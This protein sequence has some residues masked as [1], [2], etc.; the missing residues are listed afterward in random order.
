MQIVCHMLVVYV[1]PV[2]TPVSLV[3][4]ANSIGTHEWAG[5]MTRLTMRQWHCSLAQVRNINRCLYVNNGVL[6]SQQ[7]PVKC[8][9]RC[10]LCWQIGLAASAMKQL[11]FD[12]MVVSQL[13][14]AVPSLSASVQNLHI[15][16]LLLLLLPEKTKPRAVATSLAECPILMVRTVIS[17]SNN[18][19]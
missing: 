12:A 5:N 6:I 16:T 11:W 14:I 10:A 1:I 15:P 17:Q 4:L 7:N 18:P 3:V 19:T 13:T 8:L 2:K 9:S